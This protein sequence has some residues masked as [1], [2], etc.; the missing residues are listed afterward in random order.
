MWYVFS[1]QYMFM[2]L[3]A[4]SDCITSF[5]ERTREQSPGFYPCTQ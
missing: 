1:G 5:T 4:V 3:L 2:L